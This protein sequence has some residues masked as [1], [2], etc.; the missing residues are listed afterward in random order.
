[1]FNLI[2]RELKIPEYFEKMA[3]T[4]FYKNKGGRSLLQNER[5]VFNVV[6]LRS[7]LDKLIYTDT[8]KIIESNLSPS[9]VGGP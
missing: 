3:I 1:M 9:N 5:G 2:K 7:L 8:Y 4:S 6:K